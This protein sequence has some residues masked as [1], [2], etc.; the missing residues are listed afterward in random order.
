M[1][2]PLPMYAL[3]MW[4]IVDIYLRSNWHDP[5]ILSWV[6]QFEVTMH[7]LPFK[8]FFN[9]TTYSSTY[10]LNKCMILFYMVQMCKYEELVSLS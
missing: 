2:S 1:C 7:M 3:I 4:M 5:H 8:Y 10:Y 6:G 9:S